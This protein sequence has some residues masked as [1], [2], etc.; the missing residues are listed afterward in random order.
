MDGLRINTDCLEVRCRVFRP[1][2]ECVLCF[3]KPSAHCEAAKLIFRHWKS[4]LSQFWKLFWVREAICHKGST[5]QNGVYIQSEK[6]KI[7]IPLQELKLHC[8]Q[9]G[10]PRAHWP[11]NS[12]WCLLHIANW[13]KILFL[14][15]EPSWVTQLEFSRSWGFF[16]PDN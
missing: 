4:V 7:Q 12:S 6:V 14:L 9:K 15:V 13:H 10:R 2:N 11:P 5:S 3:E 16:W 8:G 1:P